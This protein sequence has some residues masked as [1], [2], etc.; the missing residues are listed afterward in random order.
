MRRVLATLAITSIGFAAVPPERATSATNPNVTACF[1]HT[2]GSTYHESV[3][4]Q[5]WTG[6][7]WS[8]IGSGEAEYN[9]CAMFSSNP[10]RTVNMYAYEQVGRATF[11]GS[12]GAHAVGTDNVHL[13]T[14]E[15]KQY[16]S[17]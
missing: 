17:N 2:N 8:T 9:G 3:F 13:G 11:N 5:E 6:S 1:K 10:N 4:F 15:V 7:S 14:Y 12:T 16:G